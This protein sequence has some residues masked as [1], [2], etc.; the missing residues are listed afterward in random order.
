MNIFRRTLIK[1]LI[2]IPLIKLLPPV[3]RA[4]A[5]MLEQLK[6]ELVKSGWTVMS[7]GDGEDR[8][9]GRAQ[10]HVVFDDDSG[11]WISI[12]KPIKPSIKFQRDNPPDYRSME[13]KLKD[14]VFDGW[15][16]KGK[17]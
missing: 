16:G 9:R 1:A 17:K 14:G 8:V 15:F 3:K 13:E 4:H 2:A 10:D 12:G 5:S 11:P 7:S 6:A